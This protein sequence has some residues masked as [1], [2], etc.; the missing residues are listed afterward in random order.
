MPR[1][2]QAAAGRRE[3]YLSPRSWRG[4]PRR[5]AR[6]GVGSGERVIASLQPRIDTVSGEV[7]DV[8][9]AFGVDIGDG[10][11]SVARE[12]GEAMEW[13]SSRGEPR[14]RG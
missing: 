10:D 4:R 1:T 2:P 5:R 13:Q 9:P 12:L 11:A 7:C 6:L 8:R 14:P 3:R